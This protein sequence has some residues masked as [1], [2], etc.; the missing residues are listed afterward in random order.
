MTYTEDINLD[1]PP[2]TVSE[3]EASGTGGIVII[4][5]PGP[6]TESGSFSFTATRT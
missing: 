2:F 6:T 3:D 1:L 4:T 5:N